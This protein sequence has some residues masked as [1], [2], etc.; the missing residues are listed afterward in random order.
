MA[1]KFL[2]SKH[3]C[4][5][6]TCSFRI[7]RFRSGWK[8]LIFSRNRIFK[9]I[10][11]NENRNLQIII[12]GKNKNP[13]IL[14]LGYYRGDQREEQTQNSK[15]PQGDIVTH[16][17]E[18]LFEFQPKSIR[19]Y[20]CRNVHFWKIFPKIFTIRC[21]FRLELSWNIECLHEYQLFFKN[22]YLIKLPE[23][24]LLRGQIQYAVE[25]RAFRESL[26]GKR[27]QDLE[28]VIF[29]EHK[30]REHHILF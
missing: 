19:N 26:S 15:G 16:V 23:Q 28:F 20:Y 10:F 21:Q 1:A 30:T 22:S 9:R 25:V 13:S 8:A 3:V 7:S 12:F 6:F 5:H 27:L 11:A 17:L 18:R 24:R 4:I 29:W 14:L 2:R